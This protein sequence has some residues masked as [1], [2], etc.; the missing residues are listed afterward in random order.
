[1]ETTETK[2]VPSPFE[3]QTVTKNFILEHH[4]TFCTSD[5]GTGK[6]RSVLD[7]IAELNVPAV[8]LA[9]KAILEPA[10]I[11][12]AKK[13][14]PE[15]TAVAAYST[16]R[17]KAF[18]QRAQLTVTNHD[19]V[20][21]LLDH[22]SLIQPESMLVVDESSA[23]KHHTSQRSK[24]LARLRKHFDRVV[25]L[26]GTPIGGNLL[27]IWHQVF[28]LDQGQRLGKSFF[29]FRN[30]VCQ[31]VSTGPGGSF[32]TWEEKEGA[33]DAVV[34]LLKDITIRF[35]M[36]D[37]IS[38]PENFTT[39]VDFELSAK[40]R[41]L[42]EQ[43]L[44]DSLLELEKTDVVAMHAA[45][46]ANKLLQIASGA[47]Y[48]G[49]KVAQTLASERYELVTELVKA[50]DQCVVAFNWGHQRDELSK[51]FEKYKI[52]YGVI[53][54]RTTT[55]QRNAAIERFQNGDLQVMLAH[56]QSASHGLTLTRGTTTIWASPTYDAERYL[57]FNRRIYRAGQ[58]KRTE[59]IHV[60]AK[61][62]IDQRVYEKLQGKLS[63][64]FALLEATQRNHK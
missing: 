12:D 26:N 27:D 62:T 7:A 32:T 16:N 21:W 38:I 20:K 18:K 50:R 45:V 1:M 47:V 46:Q 52:S 15:M 53:D 30:T 13:F 4:E 28:L 8:V 56:P 2:S 22:T 41:M 34:D 9:P 43:M 35:K 59:T 19:A 17:E 63:N 44:S 36:E 54:G 6:T 33:R 51:L 42:Y 55:K 60:A 11:E 3:H 58:T 10:W 40:H 61:D 25:L 48:D 24:A 23:F 57:Q 5:P 31:P 37:C 49:D 64:V 29:A 14:Q 39:E